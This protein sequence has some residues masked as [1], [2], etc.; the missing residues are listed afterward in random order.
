MFTSSDSYIFFLRLTLWSAAQWFRRTAPR[1]T[2]VILKTRGLPWSRNCLLGSWFTPGDTKPPRL[3]ERHQ[4]KMWERK[5]KGEMREQRKGKRWI[6]N[7]M[8]T[9]RWRDRGEMGNRGEFSTKTIWVLL[10]SCQVNE[11]HHR[12]FVL[13]KLK[14]PSQHTFYLIICFLI[15]LK[16]NNRN[17]S[18]FLEHNEHGTVSHKPKNQ[19]VLVS[20]CC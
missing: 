20:C 17:E 4:P 11:E 18:V 3:T 2:A 10:L 6:N 13:T 1:L 15:S 7:E 9:D 8:E 14:L 19:Q 12:K 16:K 5:E